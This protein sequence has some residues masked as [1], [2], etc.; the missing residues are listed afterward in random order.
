VRAH[1]GCPKMILSAFGISVNNHLSAA[2]A[3]RTLS[4]YC[5]AILIIMY[6]AR[7]CVI[8]RV[9]GHHRLQHFVHDLATIATFD[10]TAG[11]SS[12]SSSRLLFPRTR[13]S[14]TS[15]KRQIFIESFNSRQLVK[16]YLSDTHT[17]LR[18]FL[19]CPTSK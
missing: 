14:E 13:D 10:N 1:S 17:L 12:S 16:N 5:N 18:F 3:L 7:G 8:L 9:H 4:Y 6:I 2:S 11:S 15:N 19:P